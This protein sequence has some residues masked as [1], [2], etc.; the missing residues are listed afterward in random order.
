MFFFS[1]IDAIQM[2]YDDGDDNS[3]RQLDRITFTFDLIFIKIK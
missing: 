3:R 2:R 1:V